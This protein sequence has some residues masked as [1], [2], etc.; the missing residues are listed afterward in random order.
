M[1]RARILRGMAGQA[2]FVAF[3]SNLG[4]RQLV[5][6]IGTM[7]RMT[8]GTDYGAGG[9]IQL[10]WMSSSVAVQ[11]GL[12]LGFGLHHQLLGSMALVTAAAGHVGYRVRALLP[13]FMG[14]GM[15]VQTHRP[16]GFRTGKVLG[17]KGD[18]G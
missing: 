16:L 15:T 13:E 14:P 4:Q 3:Q 17:T 11:A 10:S 9:C 18:R 8:V 12:R 6:V 5:R 2:E 7:R 1:Y